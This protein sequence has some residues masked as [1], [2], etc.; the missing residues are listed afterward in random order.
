MDHSDYSVAGVIQARNN[1]GLHQGG[2][3]GFGSRVIGFWMCSAGGV[4]KVLPM[5]WL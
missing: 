3:C 2:G 1:G 5:D 4:A